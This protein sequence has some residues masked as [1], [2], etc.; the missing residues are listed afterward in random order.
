MLELFRFQLNSYR[1]LYKLWFEEDLADCSHCGEKNISLWSGTT[2]GNEIKWFNL[3][4][5]LVL[6]S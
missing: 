4:K 1:A 5:R 6:V 3:Q 2:R